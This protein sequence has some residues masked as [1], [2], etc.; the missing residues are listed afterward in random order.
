MINKFIQLLF[1][2]LCASGIIVAKDAI[3]LKG[4][5]FAIDA[6]KDINISW[7]GSPLV[8]GDSLSWIS[9]ETVGEHATTFVYGN[10]NGWQ[11]SNAW[12]SDFILPYRREIGLSPNGKKIELT[13]QAH[14]EALMDAYP[15]P[16]IRYKLL[17]PI[18]LFVN[19]SWDALT[20]R[21]QNA[22]W[23]SGTID[24]TAPEGVM[25]SG[26]RWITFYT[27]KGAVTFDFNPHG[28]PTYY[29]GGMNTMIS[30]WTVTRSGDA[31][32]LS[33]TVPATNYGGDLTSKVSIFEGDKNDYLQHHAV[34][35]YYYFSELPAERLFAFSNHAGKDFMPLS[36]TSNDD[37]AR[38]AWGNLDGLQLSQGNQSGALY[39]TCTSTKP[40]SFKTFR[41]RPGLY[42]VTL[43]TSALA[44]D[45]GPYSIA[46][47][48][49]EVYSNVTI[50]KGNMLNLTF[51]RWIEDGK[52]D[53]EFQGEWGI[54]VVGFQLFMHSEEDFQFRRGNWLMR[55][56]FCPG[57]LFA[58]YYDVPPVYGTSSSLYPLAGIVK[59]V[60]K[61]PSL[62][63]LETA[64]PDQHSP[65]LAWRFHSPIGTMGP[66]NWG[67]FNEFNTSCKIAKRLAQVKD[68]GVTA[69]ILNGF[70][71][72]HTYANHLPRV[73]ENIRKTVEIA[74]DMG[75]KIIDHQDLTILWNADMGFRFLAA[76][77]GYLQHSI[78]TGLPTWGL[79]PV[80]SG[81]KD[82]YFFPYITDHIQKTGVDGLML[83]E[84]VFHFANFCS[85]SHCR[86]SFHDTT[87]LMLP[88]DETN[89][90]LHNK[91][92]NLWK[93][94]IEWRKH[95]MAQ[96]RID[97]SKATHQINPSFSNLEYYS[98][99]G[100]LTNSASYAQGGDLPL[101]ARSKDF[102]GTEIMSRDVWDD[103][104]YNFTSRN[105]YN[106]LRETYGSPVFG[107]VYPD[108]KYNYALFGWAMNNMF[109]QVTWSLVDF[110]GSEKMND[111]TGWKK[112]MNKIQSIPYTD[113]AVLFS[114]LTRDWSVK[115]TKNYPKEVM[116]T[117]QFLSER[118]I[119]HTFILDDAVTQQA[120][121][122]FRVLLAPGMDCINNEQE[123][124]LR[125]FVTDG[126]T[127]FLTGDA[128][129]LDAYGNKRERVAFDDI[130]TDA[131]RGEAAQL[132]FIEAK[133]GRGRIVYSA[134][135]HAINEFCMSIRD[136]GM[137]Y[138]FNPDP[139]I[140][141]IN[142][143]IFGEVIGESLF[144]A[145]SIPERV[146]V[147]VYRETSENK[148]A[149]MVHL[150]NATGV[151]AKNGDRLPIP[152]PVWDRINDEIVFEITMPSLTK[153]IYTSPDEDL[154]KEVYVE[155]VGFE[156]YE[157]TIPVGT[158]DKYGILYLYP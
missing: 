8:I 135:K 43:R 66:D 125:Q 29:V 85:C 63:Q 76:N 22:R 93:A 46:L 128:G 40:N 48:G 153:A 146:M 105:M 90:L 28:V 147:N 25:V 45:I 118:H 59:D 136:A 103:Y 158:I 19:S 127:L 27:E 131:I 104:R 130:L 106:S 60:S 152:N 15:H 142:E 89:P 1:A 16:L 33:L 9:G 72:R 83:D 50:P 144:R 56:G 124:S 6:T 23:S 149:V 61:V 69:V 140:T 17:L 78:T 84:T 101:S 95:A 70:L 96:W 114:R 81:F 139:E 21:S 79:C 82:D 41:L 37:D 120:L 157:V 74:H 86:D 67:T 116:G 154:D 111:Y 112:N 24:P 30:Q 42:L 98:E 49:E 92:S 121:S 94:W 39:T 36:I 38:Y 12:N 73:E 34:S 156:S 110:E 53:I 97:L 57:I 64:L 4:S 65:K 113:V 13:F 44:D 129:T 32:E 80:N 62:P 77:P 26:T 31:I 52:A 54:S 7:K 109:G 68:G 115:N 5:P 71:S 133:F 51:V 132:P 55:G 10:H 145:I 134:K 100:F 138:R 126:G 3:T 151:K 137:V 35:S 2:L 107:L 117:G 47:N 91:E 75:M 18:S 150:L 11:T 20:G 14:Q 119:P 141:L 108:G 123:H 58:D 88:D 102:L 122:R 148:P 155:K 87:G 143:K 99:G